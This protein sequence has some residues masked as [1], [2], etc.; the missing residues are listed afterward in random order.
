MKLPWTLAIVACAELLS[1]GVVG[2]GRQAYAQNAVMENAGPGAGGADESTPE[3]KR[4]PID[5][6]GCWTGTTDDG[7]GSIIVVFSRTAP[8]RLKEK[9]SVFDFSWNSGFY[10]YGHLKGSVDSTGITFKGHVGA[11]YPVSG[12]PVSGSGTGDDSEI[13]GEFKFEGKCAKDFK[14]V[15]F[16][17]THFDGQCIIVGPK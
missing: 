7:E 15:S 16:S 2:S 4:P 6:G 9:T 12:C 1:A 10:A 5:I 17:I 3:D 13:T 11:G 8:T 14:S